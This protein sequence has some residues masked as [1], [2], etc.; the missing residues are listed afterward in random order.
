MIKKTIL[1]KLEIGEN[2]LNLIKHIHIKSIVSIA[3]NGEIMNNFP[4]KFRTNGRMSL[5]TTFIH[6]NTRNSSYCNKAGKS[7]K[8]IHIGKEE[9]KFLTCI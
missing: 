2:D 8:G 4:P 7:I 3:S 5:L 1:N 6:H 9:I